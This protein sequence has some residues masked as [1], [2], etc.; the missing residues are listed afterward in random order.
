MNSIDRIITLGASFYSVRRDMLLGPRRD[1]PIVLVR[2]SIMGALY[3]AGFSKNAIGRAFNRDHGTVIHA[4]KQLT[5]ESMGGLWKQH[6]AFI[7][8]LA[9]RTDLDDA[10]P[11]VVFATETAIS[12]LDRR[13]AAL[14]HTRG[15]LSSALEAI[16]AEVENTEAERKAA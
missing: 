5:A 12:D 1:E 11:N 13:I 14:Q 15:V 3:A 2:F 6:L 10:V 9:L 7:E 4:L 8:T 16:R